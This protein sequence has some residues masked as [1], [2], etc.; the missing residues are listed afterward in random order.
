MTSNVKIT[1]GE[2][3]GRRCASSGSAWEAAIG[4]S[5]AVRAGD[6][7][8]VTGTVGVEADGRFSPSIKGQTRRALD[9]VV[10]AIEALGGRTADVVRTRIFVTDISLWKDVGEVHGEVFAQ[11]RPALTMV[12]VSRLIDDAAMIEI[13][14]DAIVR[15]EDRE[16][17]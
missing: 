5:R 14:A 13:E 8:A 17:V 12:E 3:N 2:R 6:H 7:I 1:V 15:A 10:A 16:H 4:Y 11:V 9:I